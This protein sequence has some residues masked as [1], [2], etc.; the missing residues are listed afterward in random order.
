VEASALRAPAGLSRRPLALPLLRLRSD[1]QLLS[2]FRGGSDE[3]FAVLHD[4]Y[5]QRLFAYVRQMLSGSSRQDAE[6]VMQDVFVR[7][8]GALRADSRAVNVRA[9]LYRVAHNRCVDHLRRPVPPAA[10]I[11][12]LS[13]KPLHDPIEEAQR[14]EDLARLVEDVGRLPEQ[15]RSALLM[16]EIDGMS[17]A[18][19][20]GALSVTVPAVKSLLVRARIGLVEAAEARDADCAEIRDDLMDAYDR[21]VKASGRARRHM[22]TCSGCREYRTALRGMRHSFAALSPVAAGPVAIGA[23][24]LGLGGASG[25]AAAGGSAAAGG[26]VAAV[27]TVSACKVAAVVCTAALT[28]G[29]AVEVHRLTSPDRD[30]KGAAAAT[31]DGPS[32]RAARAAAPAVLAAPAIDRPTAVLPERVAASPRAKPARAR[33][34]KPEKAAEKPRDVPITAPVESPA[35]TET[36]TPAAPVAELP[37]T[38]GAQAPEPA[39]EVPGATGTTPP[40]GGSTPP[41]PGT[42]APPAAAPVPGGTTTPGTDTVP[43]P[44]PTG[45]L[46]DEH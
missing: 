21:G 42:T 33:T 20:A 26:G 45:P 38:G 7:A 11:F 12:E 3:A 18:D 23:K 34:H 15:Q 43:V 1:D 13:R 14:R 31:K 35:R 27:G 37:A 5:R 8:Y 28:A 22:R 6:D 17:Y 32:A 29:G 9:W 10:E 44:P 25:G 24:L 30:A 36:K 39:P 46:P 16:R 41:A 19:M 2:L 40:S 4:R